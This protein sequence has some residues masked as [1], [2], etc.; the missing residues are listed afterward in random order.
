MKV[1]ERKGWSSLNK[2]F[3][4]WYEDNVHPEWKSQKRWL[5]KELLKR[6]FIKEKQLVEM[7]AIFHSLT[8]ICSD[9]KTQGK[10]LSFITLCMNEEIGENLSSYIK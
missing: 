7:W 10:I 1:S 4:K 2:D 5:S 9:W 6:N 3:A 8:E